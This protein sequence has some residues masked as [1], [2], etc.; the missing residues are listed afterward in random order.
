MENNENIDTNSILIEELEAELDL[1][2]NNLLKKQHIIEEREKIIEDLKKQ[3]ELQKE[4]YQNII[5]NIDAEKNELLKKLESIECSRSYKIV[6]K[7]K[8]L[9]G[10]K[11]ERKKENST[12]N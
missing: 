4:Y 11:N 3:N 6:K 5:N 7:V 2:R 1:T 12:N 9:L 8:G 10:G